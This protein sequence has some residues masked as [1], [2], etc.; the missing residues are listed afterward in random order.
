MLW[1]AN[2]LAWHGCHAMDLATSTKLH[3]YDAVARTGRIPSRARLGLD[4]GLEAFELDQA[5]ASLAQQRLLI[6]APESGEIVMAPPFM[7][8]PT[9]FRVDV[10]GTDYFAPCAWDALG[11]A[12]A[13]HA[14]A[15]VHT[16][17]ADCGD[18]MEL[19]VGESGP[20]PTEAV[21]HFGVP[22][23]R[24]WDDIVFT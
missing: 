12:A 11:I 1:T 4:L 8:S 5:L 20:E 19:H 16:S 2:L 21:V 24:W 13:L 14:P 18:P 15:T 23:A 7:A 10:N 22:A 6:L 17:C 3:I 9:G